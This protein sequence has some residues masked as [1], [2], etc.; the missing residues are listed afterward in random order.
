MKIGT[1]TFSGAHNY[2]SMLQTYAL[3]AFVERL[4]KESGHPC[5]Y[6]V[7]N[8]RPKL[9]KSIYEKPRV[10]SAVS[11][12]KRLMYVPYSKRLDRQ[13]EKFEDFLRT[14]L[15]TSREFSEESELQEMAASCDVLLAGSDQIWNVRARDFSYAYLFENCTGKKVSYA[16]SLGPLNIDWSRY[17]KD[18]YLAALQQFDYISVR[19][20]KSKEMLAGIGLDDTSIH[21]DPTM[22]LNADAWRSIQSDM[23]VNGGQYILFYCLEP[24]S[25]H[26]RIAELLSKKT[27]LPIVSTGYRGKADY[28]NPFI[29]QYDAGPKDFLSLIDN[30]AIVLTSSFHGT[31]FSMIYEKP[32]F[33]IGGLQDGRIGNA[34]RLTHAEDNDLALDTTAIPRFPE[35]VAALDF[36]SSEAE[37]SREYLK[38]ALGI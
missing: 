8:Y 4:A 12:A 6:Q 16:A 38:K 3:Q 28:F 27:G 31:V 11:A 17:D 10:T 18:R 33:T 29:K 15:H 20:K 5:D 25:E 30:A 34:L 36:I 13:S 37:R 9:Q 24:R 19:E 22:L 32:F 21:V 35:P 14:E 7:L 1:M 23:S 2:G 26:L